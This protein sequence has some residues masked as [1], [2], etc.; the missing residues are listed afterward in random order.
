MWTALSHLQL[1]HTLPSDFDV[2]LEPFIERFGPLE[3]IGLSWRFD[4]L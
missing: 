3:E 2:G 1:S 4:N